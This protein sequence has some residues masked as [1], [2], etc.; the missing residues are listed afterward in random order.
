MKHTN[1]TFTGDVTLDDGEF[2]NC[3]F[4][5]SIL[6]Y[7]GGKPPTIDGCSFENVRFEFR[8]C[9]ENTVAFLKA[10]AAPNSGLQSIIRDTFPALG[11]H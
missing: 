4:D 5:G 3:T 8:G 11:A 6:I 2:I 10:M 9:A 1:K 7:S